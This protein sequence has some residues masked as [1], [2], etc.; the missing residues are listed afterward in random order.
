[1]ATSE[2]TP[3]TITAARA[4]LE[5]VPPDDEAVII[6]AITTRGTEYLTAYAIAAGSKHGG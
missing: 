1:M 6:V 5:P 2:Q 3:A 4:K